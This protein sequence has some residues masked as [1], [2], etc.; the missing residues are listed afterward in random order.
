MFSGLI[1]SVGEVSQIRER[2]LL[3]RAQFEE[4]L[5]LGESIAINGTCLTLA[6][7]RSNELRFD[8]SPETLARTNLQALTPGKRVNLE[9]ALKVS[10]RLGGH[11]VLGHIDGIGQIVEMENLKDYW[12][13]T[14]RVPQPLLPYMISKGSICVDGVSL[15]INHLWREKAHVELMIIPH[16]WAHTNWSER[17]A[18]DHVNIE[19]DYLAK[20]VIQSRGKEDVCDIR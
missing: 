15:T 7:F 3:I 16:T 19:A 11:I 9:R 13:I 14:L 18:G 6:E 4:P 1:E 8:L 2:Q 20:V 12:R 5:R 17:Q 10:D